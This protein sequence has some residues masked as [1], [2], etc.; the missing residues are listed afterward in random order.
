[1]PGAPSTSPARR[2]ADVVRRQAWIVA[3]AVAVALV[4]AAIAVH[5]A[6]P[7]YR[8]SMNLVVGQS[9]TTNSPPID[10]LNLSQTMSGLIKSDVVASGVIDQLGLKKTPQSLEKK[11]GVTVQPS[12]S[13]LEVTYDAPSPAEAERV[14]AAYSSVLK[15]DVDAKLGTG[16]NRSSLVGTTPTSV[17]FATVFDPP[18]ASA[19]AVSPHKT[20]TLLIA[21]LLG[22]A[23]GLLLAFLREHFDGRIRSRAE[24]EEAFDAPVIGGLGA[25]WQEAPSALAA[26][27]N[28][29]GGRQARARAELD[30]AVRALA[31]N[32][33]LLHAA[34]TN[35]NGGGPPRTPMIV[36]TS[37]EQGEG[38]SAV[39]ANL[40]VALA[41]AGNDVICVEADDH[42][43]SLRDYLDIEGPTAGDRNLR[44]RAASLDRLL[45]SVALDGRESSPGRL[46]VLPAEAWQDALRPR[47]HR[48]GGATLL[49]ELLGDADYVLFDAGPLAAGEASQAAAL[50]DD[51]VLVA[52]LGHTTRAGAEAARATLERL[53]VHDVAVV[54][55]DA[56]SAQI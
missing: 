6:T 5:R 18:H 45:L 25:G 38:K 43:P 15:R 29:P 54:L 2:P 37:S 26:P 28:G 7:M 50:A 14:L 9:G 47:R 52:R 51:V 20:R 23:V 42:E 56:R 17:I 46:R 48:D 21:L 19:T 49:R 34:G 22:L 41:Q 44:D 40:G 1:M 12:S 16:R 31:L 36:V 39:V 10:S 11:L 30:D 13:V 53:G 27:V 3:L 35:G 33:D 55:T 24:A 4:V 8:A 32:L